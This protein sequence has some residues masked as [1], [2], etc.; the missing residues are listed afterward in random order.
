MCR[1]GNS[2]CLLQKQSNISAPR[3]LRLWVFGKIAQKKQEALVQE[4]AHRDQTKVNAPRK[5]SR[6]NPDRPRH[7]EQI[8]SK[9]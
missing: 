5:R 7:S 2:G 8:T 4:V 1:F 6:E 9:A 3:I